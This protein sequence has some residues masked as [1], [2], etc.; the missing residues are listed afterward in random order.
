MRECKR[1]TAHCIASA[2]SVA[3][4]GGTYPGWGVPTLARG[5]LSWMGGPEVGIP[6]GWKVGTPPPPISWKVGN[7]PPLPGQLE[8]RSPPI[9]LKV[10]IPLNV[11]RQTPVKTVPSRRTTY[12][13]SNKIKSLQNGVATHSEVTPFFPMR[14]MSRASS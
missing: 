4:E 11:N 6:I 7:P 5:Y 12:G 1:H 10:G 13:G 2:C 14:A 8:G 3:G 9:G